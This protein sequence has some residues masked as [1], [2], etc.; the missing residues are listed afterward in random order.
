[1]KKILLLSSIIGLGISSVSGAA[2]KGFYVRTDMALIG[3]GHVY[4]ENAKITDAKTGSSDR[5]MQLGVAGGWGTVFGSSIY[6]GLDATLIGVSG[7]MAA[8]NDNK[9][10]FVYDPKATLRLGYAGCSSMIYVGGGL[11]ALYAFTDTKDL[12]GNHENYPL[13]KD[14]KNPLLMTLHGRVGVDFKIKG[15]W[16]VGVF[17]EYQRSFPNSNEGYTYDSTADNA[18]DAGSPA[19]GA[20]DTGSPANASSDST[21]SSAKTDLSL[22]N[23][24]IAFVFGYQM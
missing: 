14:G 4:K 13:T 12:Q 21:A 17:Y 24:R 18:Q 20:A 22:V 8:A 1:M 10:S 19:D 9:F 7:E 6:A 3:T 15:N 23:D 11:G 16:L 5:T 2:W